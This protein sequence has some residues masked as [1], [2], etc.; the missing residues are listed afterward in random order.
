MVHEIYK[1]EDDQ[2]VI[3]FSRVLPDDPASKADPQAGGA[4]G[5][6]SPTKAP[7]MTTKE[8]SLEDEREVFDTVKTGAKSFAKE[9][10]SWR[11]FVFHGLRY[12]QAK[13][14]DKDKESRSWESDIDVVLLAFDTSTGTF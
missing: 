9:N 8:E 10:Q 1:L 6:P 7:V 4:S 11:F 2:R 5:E 3:S 13:E 14:D 12:G